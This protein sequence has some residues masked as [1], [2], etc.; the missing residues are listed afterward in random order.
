[1]A[2]VAFVVGGLTTPT[3][4]N[5]PADLTERTTCFGG[6][7]VTVARLTVGDVAVEQ[8]GAEAR[9]ENVAKAV[10]EVAVPPFIVAVAT[11]E[12]D[13]EHDTG[14]LMVN[15]AVPEASVIADPLWPASGPV[16]VKVTL[17]PTTGTPFDKA[18]A[19]LVMEPPEEGHT[20]E[21]SA[22][23][24]TSL[25]PLDD[26]EHPLMTVSLPL[27]VTAPFLA[28][29]RPF[30]VPPTSVMSVNARIFPANLLPV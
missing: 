21:E 24:S 3:D 17:V 13:A 7:A 1:M 6:P 19:V 9:P 26:P 2:T 11:T 10:F 29:A 28:R 18:S 4:V 12:S 30:R 5:P 25:G 20:I 16:I 14:A 27:I 15:V 23:E 22:G 8:N